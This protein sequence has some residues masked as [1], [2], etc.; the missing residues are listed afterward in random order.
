MVFGL[1][2]AL[3]EFS[4]ERS[5]A[6]VAHETIEI[7]YLTAFSSSTSRYFINYT[8][9]LETMKE[10]EGME[11]IETRQHKGKTKGLNFFDD[12]KWI[13]RIIIIVP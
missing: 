3:V 4:C 12:A 11:Q 2:V 6:C 5:T 7:P 1:T 10:C 8:D 9:D 13:S